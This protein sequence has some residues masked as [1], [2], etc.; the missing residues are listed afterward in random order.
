[1]TNKHLYLNVCQALTIGATNTQ[2]KHDTLINNEG[3]LLMVEIIGRKFGTTCY[4]VEEAIKF[5]LAE[6][7][8]E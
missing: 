2:S 7:I 4:D 1:M 8:A 3:I 6:T 5:L